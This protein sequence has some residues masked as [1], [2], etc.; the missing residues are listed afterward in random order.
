ML[1]PL[2]GLS[3]TI[4]PE[5]TSARIIWAVVAVVILVL[6]YLMKRARKNATREYWERRKA[7]EERIANDP[8]MRKD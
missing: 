3:D 1:Y 5:D 6:Y 4:V 8:D 7:E 2:I